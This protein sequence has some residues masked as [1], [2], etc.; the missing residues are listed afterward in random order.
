MAT[1]QAIDKIQLLDEQIK[2]LGL[3]GGDEI[4]IYLL[5]PCKDGLQRHRLL[6]QGY[7]RIE[8]NGYR[9]IA[10]S[11]DSTHI[12]GRKYL[13]DCLDKGADIAIAFKGHRYWLKLATWKPYKG[14]LV[15][16]LGQEEV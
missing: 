13:R 12:D 6:V 10:D 5:H 8:E 14:A 7:L 11:D 2:L 9:F 3:S 15:T 16:T 4:R 1:P